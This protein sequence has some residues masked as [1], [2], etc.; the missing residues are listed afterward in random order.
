ML[1]VTSPSDGFGDIENR[2]PDEILTAVELKLTLYAPQGPVALKAMVAVREPEDEGVYTVTFRLRP[3]P[4]Q[5]APEGTD[6]GV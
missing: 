4:L 6:T 1:T 3:P 5:L 2:Q